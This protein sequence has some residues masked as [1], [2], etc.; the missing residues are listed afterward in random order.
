MVGVVC[1]EGFPIAAALSVVGGAGEGLGAVTWDC[2]RASK[3]DLKNGRRSPM[4]SSSI[5]VDSRG[6][7]GGGGGKGGGGS[8]GLLLQD[9]Y[10]EDEE[11]MQ[12]A[13][14]EW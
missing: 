11:K 13:E 10:V 12:Q 9:R 8:I 2:A 14:Y 5:R 4:T 1:I 7:K 6:A 3:R